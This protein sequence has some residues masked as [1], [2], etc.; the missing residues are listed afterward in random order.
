MVRDAPVSIFP[1][2]VTACNLITPLSCILT[3]GNAGHSEPPR[4]AIVVT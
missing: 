3:A 4:Y 2:V 1:H